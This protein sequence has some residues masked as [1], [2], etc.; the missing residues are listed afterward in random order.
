MIVVTT[1]WAP[2]VALRKPGMKPHTAPNSIPAHSASGMPMTAGLSRSAAPTATAPR[3]PIR[4]CPVTP[5]LNRPALKARPTDRPPSSSGT[6]VT[7]VLMIARSEPTD[8]SIRAANASTASPGW[9]SPVTSQLEAM[10]TIEPTRRD[11][12]IAMSGSARRPH[13]LFQPTFHAAVPPSPGAT[14]SRPPVAIRMPISF[15]SAV[16]PSR[17]ATIFPR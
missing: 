3:A 17:T 13:V 7:S 16:L 5:M 9:I 12:T 15:L 2:E 11:S 4:N 1:S 8:P 10:M 14:P 6:V